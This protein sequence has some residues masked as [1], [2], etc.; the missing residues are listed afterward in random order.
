MIMTNMK[1]MHFLKKKNFNMKKKLSTQPLK[2][3]IIS[4]K[5]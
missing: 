4:V 3:P 1:T 5:K 2:K